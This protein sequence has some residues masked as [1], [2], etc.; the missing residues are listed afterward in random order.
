MDAWLQTATSYE[1]DSGA[2]VVAAG[3]FQWSWAIDRYG[4]RSYHGV[5][6]PIDPRVA[7]MTRNIFDRLG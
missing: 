7:I 4:G 2:T 1:A 3:T 6:T 5:S